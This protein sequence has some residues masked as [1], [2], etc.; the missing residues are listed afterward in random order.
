MNIFFTSLDP[1]EAAEALDD[2]RLNKMILE[3]AQL[4]SN[5]TRHKIDEQPTWHDTLAEVGLAADAGLLYKKT[6]WNHPSSVWARTSPKHYAWLVQHFSCLANEKRLRDVQK[7]KP[8]D[9]WHLSYSKLYELFRFMAG[10]VNPTISE[11]DITKAVAVDADLKERY[12]PVLAYRYHMARKWLADD[13]PV[14]GHRHA[15]VWFIVMTNQAID[16]FDRQ[17][18]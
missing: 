1:K 15:P 16:A 3:T 13:N 14:W 5:A 18:S 11:V 12:G 4:L 6:H 10:P 9:T 2:K 17:D 8:V 7:G